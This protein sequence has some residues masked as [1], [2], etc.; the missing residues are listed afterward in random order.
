MG[1]QT[2]KTP[3]PS[4]CLLNMK[5]LLALPRPSMSSMGVPL[6]AERSE[7]AMLRMVVPP[8]SKI[9]KEAGLKQEAK[10]LNYP[11]LG[12]KLQV[13]LNP[14]RSRPIVAKFVQDPQKK[15]QQLLS[16]SRS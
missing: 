4:K 8:S 9:V 1:C 2:W 10:Q 15:D 3:K 16:E 12:Q 14:G 5:I 7:H 6:E 13:I 11:K